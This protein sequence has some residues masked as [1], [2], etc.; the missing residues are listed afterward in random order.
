MLDLASN[1]KNKKIQRTKK[2]NSGFFL[3]H[4]KDIWGD[5]GLPS[6][7]VV[8]DPGSITLSNSVCVPVGRKETRGW[9]RGISHFP[10]RTFSRRCTPLLFISSWPALSFISRKKGR[11]DSMLTSSL[12]CTQPTSISHQ[13]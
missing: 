7:Q 10:L 5:P 11:V 2:F 12:C 3:S 8:R 1:D 9:V 13:S 4:I 6:T